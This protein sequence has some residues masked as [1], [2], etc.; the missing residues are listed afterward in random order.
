MGANTKGRQ[1]YM[2]RYRAEHKDEIF[3]RRQQYR[4][5]HA[6]EIKA[7]KIAYAVAH[8]EELKAKKREY[9]SANKERFAA[10]GKK[11]YQAHRSERIAAARRWALEHP[12]KMKAAVRR[13]TLKN[14][15][16]YRPRRRF[17]E[18]ERQ[19]RKRAN[20]GHLTREEWAAVKAAYGQR[21]AYCG[22]KNKRLTQDHVMPLS[23]G[24]RH[25]VGNIVPACLGCNA[26]K[27]NRPVPDGAALKL[28]ML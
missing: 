16:K 23:K 13:S 28:L 25:E 15:E 2:R 3:L 26:S 4:Q 8:A 12:E 17:A 24:G 1:E 11:R 21:C 9:Y 19:H 5:E 6:E 10:Y 20:G 27:G 14:I 18:N 22:Q 7:K